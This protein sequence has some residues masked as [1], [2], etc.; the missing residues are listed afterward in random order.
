MKFPLQL[1]ALDIQ[2]RVLGP[3]HPNTALFKDN[4]ACILALADKRDE[5]LSLLREAVDH[6]LPPYADLYIEEDKDLKSLHGDPRFDALVAH[7]KERAAAAM[8]KQ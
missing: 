6:G 3:E 2:R 8:K 4:L 5:A 1:K 7:A